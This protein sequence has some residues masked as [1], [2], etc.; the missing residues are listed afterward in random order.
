MATNIVIYATSNAD[1]TGLN[2]TD[3]TDWTSVGGAIT[4]LTTITINIY[5]QSLATPEYTYQLSSAERLSYVTNGTIEL[6]FLTIAGVLNLNDAWWSCQITANSENYVSNYSGF[7]IYGDITFAVFSQ[8]N[9]LYVPADTKYTAERYCMPAII[10]K[11]LGFLDTTNINSRDV[12][13]TKNL[14]SLQK[15]LL[16]V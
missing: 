12:K 3:Q 6:S 15:M 1:Q 7:G 2:I 5:G 14:L 11:G 8:V 9:D 10:L 13:F 16:R 4:D